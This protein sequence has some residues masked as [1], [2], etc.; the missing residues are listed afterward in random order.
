MNGSVVFLTGEKGIGKSTLCKKIADIVGARGYRCAGILSPALFN[1]RGERV[2]FFA[3]DISTGRS[4]LLGH[5]SLCL[6]GP[7]YG[8][9]RFS[10]RGFRKAERCIRKS[11]KKGCDILMLDEVGPL[12]MEMGEGF[13]PILGP[14]LNDRAVTLLCVVRPSLL[15]AVSLCAEDRNVITVELSLENREELQDYIVDALVSGKTNH[16]EKIE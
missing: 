2:G 5:M 11:R 12:E 15:N 6:R 4:W 1:K 13:F 16:G 3:F 14:L 8:P 7:R 10:M 9:Y